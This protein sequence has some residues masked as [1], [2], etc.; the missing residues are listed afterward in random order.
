MRHKL[1]KIIKLQ[2]K[3]YIETKQEQPT[4]LY[5]NPDDAEHYFNSEESYKKL[6]IIRHAG[7]D[8]GAARVDGD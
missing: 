3:Q 6:T 7:V 1:E 8:R 5:L 4:I 2:I